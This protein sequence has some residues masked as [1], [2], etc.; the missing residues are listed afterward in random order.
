[1]K[2]WQRYLSHRSAVTGGFLVVVVLLV[3]AAA[4]LVATQDPFLID[5]PS[6]LQASSPEHVLGTDNFG[7]DLWARIAYGAR[8]T[9]TTALMAVAISSLIGVPLGLISGYFGGVVDILI[10]RVVDVVLAF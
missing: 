5:L 1:M 6:R 7:R 4:P 8:T 9:L 2:T 3:G 10:S